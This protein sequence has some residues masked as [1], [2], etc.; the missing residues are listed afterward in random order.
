MDIDASDEG[1][2]VVL[3]QEQNSNERVLAYA[4]RTLSVTERNYSITR[5]E[6]PAVI[7]G[8]K[9]FRPYLIG[10][11]FVIRT[12]HAAWQWLSQTTNRS[13]RTVVRCNGRIRFWR[14][15][16]RWLAAF[17][18]RCAFTLSIPNT[19]YLVDTQAGV[20]N[21]G[22]KQGWVARPAL[23]TIIHSTKVQNT[24]SHNNRTTF[25]LDCQTSR[26]TH[27]PSAFI[28]YAPEIFYFSVGCTH[29]SPG[30]FISHRNIPR[31]EY[32]IP[33]IL[34]RGILYFAA[35]AHTSQSSASQ[36]VGQWTLVMIELGTLCLCRVI[37][38]YVCVWVMTDKK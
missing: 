36:P 20:N 35:P 33:R 14:A 27:L 8:L 25:G 15:A 2:G 24:H 13:S 29:S 17:E 7:F 9:K 23:R 11:R 6:L 28:N 30:W 1:L 5:K 34:F 18:C 32:I 21:A 37:R 31:M 4:S 22:S 16:P 26:Q 10:R 38:C 19:L 3:S 12:D